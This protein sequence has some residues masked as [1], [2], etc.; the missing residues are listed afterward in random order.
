[1]PTQTTNQSTT[2][3][4]ARR[5]NELKPSITVALNAHS[6][7]QYLVTSAAT[8]LFGL[9]THPSASSRRAAPCHLLTRAG[10]GAQLRVA[11]RAP[12]PCK[13]SSAR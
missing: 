8:L 13:R 11:A 6:A 7:N 12:P 10:A 9:C 4:L 1:M 5:V 3:D 2:L